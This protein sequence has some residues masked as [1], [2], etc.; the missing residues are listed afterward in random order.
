[1]SAAATLVTPK[2]ANLL[3]DSEFEK[4]FGVDSPWVNFGY[5]G[6][7]YVTNDTAAKYSGSSSMKIDPQ[8]MTQGR[9]QTVT[10]LPN[11]QYK[12]SGYL[13]T[14]FTSTAGKMQCDV[15]GTGIDSAGISI[16]SV[17]GPVDWTYIEEIVTIPSGTTSVTVRCFVD[18][19]LQ[20]S[21]WFDMVQFVPQQTIKLSAAWVS[22]GA[23]R[24]DWT[25]AFKD[26]SGFKVSR[27]AWNVGDTACTS[28]SQLG[29]ALAV[30]Q[31]GMI[32]ASVEPDRKYTYRVEAF[33]T[34][35]C[36][37]P[38]T[39]SNEVTVIASLNAPGKP[40]VVALDTTRAK[41][42]WSSS[43]TT[44]TGFNIFRS[45]SADGGQTWSA[46]NMLAA[47]TSAGTTSL[48][49][50]TVCPG[51]QVRYK[52]QA[53]KDGLTQSGTEC[54]KRSKEITVTNHQPAIQ[55]RLIVL[56]EPLMKSDYSDLR[57]YDLAAAAELPYWIEKSDAASATVWIKT[58]STETLY[59]YYANPTATSM[60][61][62]QRVFDFFDSFDGLT[63]NAARWQE[64]DT[65]AN[66][67]T[68]NEE[69]VFGRDAQDGAAGIYSLANFARP[70]I[71]EVQGVTGN[72]G[73]DVYLG[74]K[75]ISTSITSNQYVHA[76]KVNW[77]STPDLRVVDADPVA[78]AANGGNI[79]PNVRYQY[80]I[81]V[82]P[83][84]TKYSIG[85]L[86]S[87]LTTF[88]T[89]PTGTASPLKVALS[90]SQRDMRIDNVRVRRY[91]AVE[92]TASF[93]SEVILSSCPIFTGQWVSPES[94]PSDATAL[95]VPLAPIL[96]SVNSKTDTDV[97]LVWTPRTTDQSGYAILRCDAAYTGS[98]TP[99]DVGLTV[100]A[101]ASSFV[102]TGR[103]PST[104]YCYQVAAYKS[105][106]CTSKWETAVSGIACD[107]TMS[108]RASD[109]TVAPI[110]SRA[111]RL[112]WKA[113]ADVANDEEGFE[114]ETL[115]SHAINADITSNAAIWAPITTVKK[116]LNS[117]DYLYDHAQ[118]LAPNRTY[119]YRVRPYR[120][121]D[122][123][124]YT[125]P[126]SGT[127]YKAA[128]KPAADV[129]PP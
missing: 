81:D 18:G 49:D 43:F 79:T 39:F 37:W 31:I 28:F 48:V 92:P 11:E 116:K 67:V 120:G 26:E 54:W 126:A 117:D 76:L 77:Y 88:A 103:T 50:D 101:G 60:S 46:Y 119:W 63:I 66:F 30:D 65:V 129:C 115:I 29:S 4:V 111:V 97:E 123:S 69:L 124:P 14:N 90:T 34:A 41:V 44:E 8:G 55:M 53:Y 108:G 110:T 127:T 94:L 62:P 84:G 3:T 93:G 20:G 42:D 47:K 80:R 59:M 1:M 13:K 89:G 128:D 85:L 87:V 36:S 15:Q 83:V 86:N 72:Q 113:N 9:G 99:T 24:L 58:G 104:K 102:D 78:G 61:N 82:M 22:E 33:K 114:I 100:S 52:V 98:C 121:A 38:Q 107:L 105:A 57:F 10:V 91:T 51:T 32:D 23:I 25:D 109:L 6:S 70:F 19:A 21:A 74:L 95:P 27:C 7:W 40:V 73:G 122:K 96:T 56:R 17:L 112:T 2:P 118:G 45:T 68:Q 35:T 71:F 5:V 125:A 64:V 106:L 75:N 12:L 16:P